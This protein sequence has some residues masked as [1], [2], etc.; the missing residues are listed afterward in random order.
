MPQIVSTPEGDFIL[1]GMKTE[2]PW[3]VKINANGK[4]LWNNSPEGGEERS[5]DACGLVMSSEGYYVI[6]VRTEENKDK[7]LVD[8][9]DVLKFLNK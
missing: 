7:R 5:S 3:F 8:K 4:V 9:I 2:M 6:F 1:A